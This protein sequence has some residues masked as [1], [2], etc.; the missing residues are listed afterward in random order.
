[1]K[2]HPNEVALEEFYLSHSAEH[3]ALL[4]HLVQ[5]P[6]CSRRLHGVTESAGKTTV[7]SREE[8]AAGT[9][10]EEVLDRVESR[11]ADRERAVAKERAAA[12]A[13]FVE[14][15]KLVPE[16]QRLLLRNSPRFRTWS[17]CELLVEQ[18]RETTVKDPRRVEDLARLSLDVAARLDTS[19]YRAGLIQDLQARAWAY[20]GNARR[21]LSD[22]QGAEKAFL[23]AET[24]LRQ[25]SRD[26]VELAIFLDLKASLRRSQRRFEDALRLLRRAVT[27]FRRTG[28]FHRAGRSLINMDLIHCYAG[29][30]EQGIPLLYEAI[31]LVD[32]DLD[33]RLRLCA[34]HNLIQDLAETGRYFEAQKLYR[35]TCPLYREFPEPWAQNRRKWVKAKISLGQEKTAQAERLFLATRDGFM[36]DGISYDTALVSLELAMLY[37]RQERTA[38]LKRLAEEMLPVFSSLQIHREALVALCF[39]RKALEAE[40]ASLELVSRVANFLRRAEHDPG[41]RF[42][43]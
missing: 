34:Q 24:L 19:Y 32:V 30:P 36:A 35:E 28:H 9:S 31:E 29:N 39:L 2:F 16:Q 14:I 10:Y 15:M 12:P 33:P 27:I 7:G 20:V 42:E 1:M 37:A 4:A 18:C 25:G 5:C 21:V 43:P 13:L 17:L 38:D 23:E 6:Q 11:M 40:Q 3:Q 26:L 8:S 22:L 41:L